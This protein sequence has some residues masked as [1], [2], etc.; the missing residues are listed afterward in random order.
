MIASLVIG[1]SLQKRNFCD[2]SWLASILLDVDPKLWKL[3]STLE[4]AI[5]GMSPADFS[6]HQ[7]GKWSSA[8]ILDHLNLTYRGTIRN[9]ER[10]LAQGKPGASADRKRTRWQRLGLLGLGIF[11]PRRK[12]PERVLPRGTPLEPLRKEIFENIHRMDRVIAECDVRFGR[13]KP[14]AE[15]PVLG[16]LTASEWCKFH[17]VHGRHHARQ[18][19]RLNRQI[20]HL[21]DD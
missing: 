3:Q 9:C 6:R 21:L 8:E 12:S 16:P 2:W 20:E 11:P 4:K 19:V 7:E 1:A 15:H 13:G 14:I 5:E 18:I 10:C 17:L